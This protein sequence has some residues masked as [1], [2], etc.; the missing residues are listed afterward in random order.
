MEDE[1]THDEAD[2]RN[3]SLLYFLFSGCAATLLFVHACAKL[4]D[5]KVSPSILQVHSKS[6]TVSYI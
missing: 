4:A 6:A 3:M 1:W 5:E 2:A